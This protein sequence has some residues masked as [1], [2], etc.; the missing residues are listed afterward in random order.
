MK[1]MKFTFTSIALTF[2]I[3][4]ITGC[5]AATDTETTLSEHTYINIAIEEGSFGMPFV[6]LMYDNYQGLTENDY[7]F[8]V[9]NEQ[10]IQEGLLSSKFDIGTVDINI[11]ASLFNT[12]GG[13]IKLISLNSYS[14]NFIL[15]RSQEIQNIQDLRGKTIHSAGRGRSQGYSFVHILRENGIDPYADLEIVW[16]YNHDHVANRFLSREIDIVLLPK[17]FVTDVMQKD[18][19][20]FI[21]LDLTI[22]WENVMNST[23]FPSGS[24]V[25]RSE[26]LENNPGAVI[27]FL[28]EQETSVE[29]V[30]NDHQKASGLMEKFSITR[31]IIAIDTLPY[32]RIVAINGTDLRL[33]T[34][35]FLEVMYYS[36]AESLG[37][38]L[39]DQSF[40]FD[41][42]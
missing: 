10:V 15:S 34:Q 41:I 3:L 26:F 31:A 6:G 17:L 32:K 27:S 30:V 36:N 4:L 13:E 24:T 7:Y 37:G 29:F 25:V 1:K 8:T 11:A 28:R 9:T 40:W 35:N 5:T 42:D 14:D 33:S 18:E 20:I 12:T 21:A 2:F 22:E 38:S 19:S 16:Y 39:P 23:P